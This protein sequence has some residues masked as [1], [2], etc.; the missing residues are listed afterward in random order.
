M[1]PT[2]TF[3]SPIDIIGL[4][5]VA[6]IVAGLRARL[7]STKV[8]GQVSLLSFSQGT[9]M[10][11]FGDKKE[12]SRWGTLSCCGRVHDGPIKVNAKGGETW[13]RSSLS[14]KD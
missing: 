10:N 14:E 2:H 3:V 6:V 1:I 4:I 7:E 9:A 12:N 5:I 8:T 11:F 13:C